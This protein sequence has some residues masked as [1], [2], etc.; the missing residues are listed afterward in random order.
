MSH[1]AG[2]TNLCYFLGE[3]TIESEKVR[4]DVECLFC[5]HT[6]VSWE[7]QLTIMQCSASVQFND[8]IATAVGHFR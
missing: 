8:L 2:F 6:T 3:Y 1:R 7:A 5:Y 4:I